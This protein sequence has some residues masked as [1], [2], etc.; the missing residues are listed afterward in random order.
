MTTYSHTESIYQRKSNIVF[1]FFGG[2]KERDLKYGI[3]VSYAYC[4]FLKTTM[5][6]CVF[7]FI[8]HVCSNL[9]LNRPLFI[10]RSIYLIV[11]S[12]ASASLIFI[13]YRVESVS[14]FILPTLCI[15]LQFLKYFAK[16]SRHKTYCI[17]SWCLLRGFYHEAA[18]RLI[19]STRRQ[20][21]IIVPT[22]VM[23]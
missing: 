15:S 1:C 20:Q 4:T 18:S 21:Q 19:G 13:Y 23:K 8:I 5:R 14:S 7:F 2:Y 6:N 9:D 16:Q 12:S 11:L 22:E 17:T 3:R 10:E